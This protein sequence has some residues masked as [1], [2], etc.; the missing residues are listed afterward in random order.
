MSRSILI[1]QQHFSDLRN[2]IYELSKTVNHLE[3]VIHNMDMGILDASMIQGPYAAHHKIRSQL[4]ELVVDFQSKI[5]FLSTPEILEL[6]IP[7]S[8][9]ADDDG[10][11]V[12]VIFIIITRVPFDL[13]YSNFL[14][15]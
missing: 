14:L 11:V 7:A 9:A 3:Y 6:R 2:S 15:Y 10:A 13:I 5:N 4:K 8:L 12:M 1:E